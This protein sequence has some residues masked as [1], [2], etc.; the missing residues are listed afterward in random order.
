MSSYQTRKTPGDISWFTHDRFGMFIH[1]GVYAIPARGEWMKTKEEIPDEEYERYVRYFD[2]DL[3]DPREWAKQA[4]AAG[5]KYA[6][7][8][9]KHH[10]GFCLFD[11]AYTDYKATNTPCGRD[12]VKEY[13]DAFR[14]EGLHVGLYYS[15][16]DWH[17]PEFPI[18]WYHPLRKHPD[19]EAISSTRNMEIYVE[20]MKNQLREL[21]TG[22]GRIDIL[23]FDFSY[24]D[25][26][27]TRFS[28]D[29]KPWMKAKGPDEWHSQELIDMVRELQPGIVINNRA[30]LEQDIFTPEQAHDL[31]WIRHKDTGELVNWEMCQ[32]LS[33]TWGYNRDETTWKSPE[34]LI[35]MLISTVS[36]GG[37]LILNVGPTGRGY[38]DYR[39]EN[40]LSAIGEWMKY[41]S[42]A[43]YGCTK[44]E[45]EFIV[46]KGCRLTQSEDGKRLYVH[47]FDYPFRTL[48]MDDIADKVAHAQF[49][50]DASEIA[51]CAELEVAGV[52][53][54]VER[55]GVM[56][57][58]PAVKPN[59]TVPVLEL[60][61]K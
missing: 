19:A 37:N 39:A 12:L 29:V 53:H 23:W 43:I 8:T 54:T 14:A 10:D 46:P 2:P 33:G 35:K 34:M 58:L 25:H 40:A 16:L 18:D 4:K 49:L 56:F 57:L 61:L 5:M 31:K 21:M 52:V 30:G 51:M 60:F 13:A 27:E 1:F 36:E 42:R 41:N 32:T 48:I 9:T 26:V 17:H 24:P 7:L 6:V 20:Y 44:A 38:L 15:L 3:C 22:Y 55:N 47:L 59:V 28:P 50:H 45:P 11:S